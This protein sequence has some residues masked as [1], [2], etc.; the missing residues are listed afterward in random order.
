MKLPR[1]SPAELY[2]TAKETA[3]ALKKA[4]QEAGLL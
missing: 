2:A 3:E 4:A 1:K